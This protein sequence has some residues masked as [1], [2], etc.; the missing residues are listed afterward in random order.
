MADGSQDFLTLLSDAVVARA[1]AGQGLVATISTGRR[2]RTGIFWGGDVV[3]ASEQS[4][5]K[6]DD[7]T[8]QLADGRKLNAQVA[9]RDPSTNIIALRLE[10]PVEVS[11]PA[12]AE[13][14]L[15]ALALAFGAAGDGTATVRL[16][17]IRA[18]GPAWHSL[19]GGLIDR[20]MSLDLSVSSGQEGGPVLSADGGLLGM[21]TAGP[22]GR[23]IVIP[24]ATVARV[25]PPLLRTGKIER[26]W[27]GVALH[28]VAL[29]AGSVT[30]QERGQMVMQVAA[31]G[32]AAKAGVQPG[33]I[34]VAAGGV[35]AVQA[36]D[37]GRRLGPDSVGQMIELRLFRAGAP[38]TLTATITA[39]PAA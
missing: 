21:S 2:P 12:T 3:V 35:A 32:P 22:R 7:A 5:P 14:Q 1:A 20:R 27:L 36:R 6:A 13:P 16:T 38:L 18:M 39:R 34:L 4:F 8:V 37:L 26:G 19:R 10:Q 30:A 9:G 15:G 25:L 11:L 31:D 33:D 23:A 24:A 17:S 28:P 29:P